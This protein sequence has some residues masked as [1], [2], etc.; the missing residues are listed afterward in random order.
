M[1]RRPISLQRFLAYAVNKYGLDGIGFDNEYGGT[2]TSV[3]GW[4]YGDLI[5]NCARQTARRQV[6]YPLPVQY[7]LRSD[8]HDSRSQARP[9]LF[10]LRFT[11]RISAL[12]A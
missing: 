11:T 5:A 7:R 3:S 10:Q 2:V 8:Q 6:G 4:S 9:C 12:P 1:T